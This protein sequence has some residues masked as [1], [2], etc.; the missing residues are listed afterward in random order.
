MSHCEKKELK[1][2]LEEVKHLVNKLVKKDSAPSDLEKWIRI[3]KELF[4]Q[5]QKE[6]R[7][8]LGEDTPEL[9]RYNKIYDQEFSKKW[10]ATTKE[11]LWAQIAKARVVLMGDFHAL[12]QAQKA[13]V[14]VLRGVSSNQ[15]IILAVEFFES[16]D[17]DKIEKYLSGKINERDFLEAIQWQSR[18]GFL[19]EYYRPLMLWAQKNKVPVFGINKGYRKRNA[20]TLKS[21]DV[22]AGKKIAELVKGHSESLVFVIYGDLHLAQSHIPDE[23]VKNLGEPFRKK[24]LRIFQNAEKIY[25]QLLRQELESTTD[26]VR[27]P[28]STYCLMSVPPWVKWQNYLMY[29]EQAYDV[30]L[31]DDSESDDD[32]L[33]F[34][35]HVGRYVKI[36]SEELGQS[37]SISNLSVYTA[38]DS[39]FWSQVRDKY[40]SKKQKWI[41]DLIADEVSFYLPEIEA[42]YLAR[43]SVNHAASLAMQFIHAQLSDF[44]KINTEV[45]GDFSRLIWIEAVSY[46]GSKM[47]NHKRK[48]DTIADIKASLSSRDPKDGGKEALQ[49]ALARKMHELMVVTGHSKHRLQTQPRRKWSYVLAARFL[50]GMMGERLYAGYRNKLVSS[51]NIISFLKKP[52]SN[53][54]FDVAYFGILEVVEALPTPFHSKKEKL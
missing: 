38:Q 28:N 24:I 8:R 31:E 47:I 2:S 12:H 3:R 46:F 15:K 34:T 30:G 40:D 6:V 50:G 36:I 17:Q 43:G 29:L 45:P 27:M 44:K 13:Q 16:L 21:R 20:N 49:L 10:E 26:I 4:L 35:E 51:E 9:M 1:Y 32:H 5:M 48:T 7:Y 14:R 33:D 54:H 53:E 11:D 19:W 22:F 41:Q 52:T 25:F 42:A 37:V 23:I 39:A 18:W